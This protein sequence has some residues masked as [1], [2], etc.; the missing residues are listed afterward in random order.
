MLNQTFTD[1]GFNVNV[2]VEHR[3]DDDWTETEV[4]PYVR[5]GIPTDNAV[6]ATYTLALYDDMRLTAGG[7][8]RLATLDETDSFVEDL[9]PG[10]PLY[11][12]VRVRV[13]IW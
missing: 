7:G 10:R 13:V 6:S 1:R 3:S 5:R 11:N 9:Y 8:E 2:Y 4:R 12:V